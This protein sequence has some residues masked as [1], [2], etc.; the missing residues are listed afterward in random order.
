MTLT[1]RLVTR[2]AQLARRSDITIHELRSTSG[3]SLTKWESVMPPD[4]YAFY[5][6][7][8]GITFYYGI[9]GEA[10]SWH[11]M[12]FIS[13]DK[14]GKK[15]F[16]V[17]GGYM[18]YTNPRKN[19]KKFGEYFFQD[20]PDE[21]VTFFFGSDDA[22]GVLM[23]G[24]GASASFSKW[25]NDGFLNSMGSSFTAIVDQLIANNFAHTWAYDAHPDT[26]KLRALL[27]REVPLRKTFELT[28][29]A[30]ADKSAHDLRLQ[31]IGAATD[32][33]IAKLI[34][35]LGLPAPAKGATRADKVAL[36]TTAC[37][38]LSHIDEETAAAM[39]TA[40]KEHDRTRA[41]LRHYLQSGA[42]QLSYLTLKLKHVIK[43][44]TFSESSETLIRAL[45][46]IDGI[47]FAHDLPVDPNLFQA[48]DLHRSGIPWQPLI[49]LSWDY[50]FKGRS[51]A[52][53]ATFE[54]VMDARRAEGLEAGRTYDSTALAAP[55]I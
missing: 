24:T 38:D 26:E 19:G 20:P 33:A 51:G 29:E 39:M 49:G 1:H 16:N 42:D 36:I 15:M 7:L 30:R 41:G 32:P 25:D 18:Y 14:D 40:L 27:A 6:S 21:D 53:T 44:A 5:K 28:V 4:M 35:L 45:A 54:V 10:D 12:R 17:K 23:L 13:A 34:K 48:V 9:D 55:I 50:S 3:S 37:A 46:A 47:S 2:I 31:R 52:K 22:W 43:D 8:N 11:G